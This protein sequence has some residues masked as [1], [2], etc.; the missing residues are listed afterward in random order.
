MVILK[1][2]KL[3]DLAQT[4]HFLREHANE[5]AGASLVYNDEG[6]PYL[7]PISDGPTLEILMSNSVNLEDLCDLLGAEITRREVGRLKTALAGTYKPTYDDVRNAFTDIN[8]RLRDELEKIVFLS[9]SSDDKKYFEPKA[10]LFG[11]QFAAKFQTEGVFE[12]DE[13]AKC[14]ALG[15]PT[16]SVFHLMRIMEISIRATARCLHIPDPLKPAERNWGNMLKALREGI[17]QKWPTTSSRMSDDGALFD[18]IYASLDA[19]KNPWRNATMHVE[20]KYTDDEA[21]HIFTAVRGFVM[22]LAS[23]CD[24]NGDPKAT[25]RFLMK[26]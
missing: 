14:R 8:K 4:V 26:P 10:P 16:A 12:L 9:L 20:K 23:R 15:R 6:Q 24:E 22:K 21:E 1:A 5:K 17:D 2:E 11:Q 13:A 19:V 25:G 7:E 18:E 3:Y